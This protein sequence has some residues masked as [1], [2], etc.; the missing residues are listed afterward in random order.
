MELNINIF[1]YIITIKFKRL[2]IKLINKLEYLI[3]NF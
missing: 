2:I 3:L 1:L